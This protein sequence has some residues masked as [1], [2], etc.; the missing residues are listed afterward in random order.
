MFGLGMEVLYVGGGGCGRV[1]GDGR[2]VQGV[3]RRFDS[4]EIHGVAHSFLL[5]YLVFGLSGRTLFGVKKLGQLKS[6]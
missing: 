6:V 2:W 1:V 3:G 4:Q 5:P